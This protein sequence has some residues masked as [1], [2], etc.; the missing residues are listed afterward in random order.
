M[1]NRLTSQFVRS[2]AIRRDPRNPNGWWLADRSS[3]RYF[4]DAKDEVTLLAGSDRLGV[5]DGIGPRAQF[6]VIWTFLV[7]SDGGTIWCSQPGAVRRIDVASREVKTVYVPGVFDGAVCDMHWDRSP[8]L[9]PDSAIYCCTDLR[10]FSRFD[11]V[12]GRMKAIDLGKGFTP[13]RLVIHFDVTRPP[14]PHPA[15]I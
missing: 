13:A 4:D 14:K 5:A 12:T 3:I 2:K 6:A 1:G 10:R 11:C 8:N 7:S 9:K 15:G